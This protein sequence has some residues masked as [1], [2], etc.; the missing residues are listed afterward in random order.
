MIY[1]ETKEI[2]KSYGIK[3]LFEG[4]SFTICEGDKIALV[5]GNGS[6]KS[7][8]MKILAAQE[9]TDKGQ[10]LFSKDA[11]VLFFE[12]DTIYDKN[13][14]AENFLYDFSHP[15][16][17]ALKN[18]QK[19]LEEIDLM[20]EALYQMEKYEVWSL[21]AQMNQILDQLH[22][23]P[24]TSRMENLSGG[25]VKRLGLAKLLLNILLEEGH[26]LLMLDEPTN[27]LDTEMVEWLEGYVNQQRLTLLMVTHD[28]IFLD[29]TCQTIWE[30]DGGNL[31][32]HK[33]DYAQYLMNKSNRMDSMES[34]IGK[35]KNLYRKEL[36][37]MRRQ[38]K[39]RTSKSKSRIDA[40][41][42]TQTTA[43]QV[44]DTKKVVLD[45]QMTRLGGKI[46]EMK[47]VSKSYG[48]LDILNK[49]SYVFQKGDRIGI[50]GKNG[51]GKSTFLNIIQGLEPIDGGVREVGETVAFGYYTQKGL[52]LPATEQRVIEYIKDIAEF[53]PL[54]NGKSLSASQ[55]LKRFLFN[56]DTQHQWVS[57][58]SGGER[59]RLHLLSVL[60]KNP[61]FLILDEPTNDLD[62][63][64]LSILEDFLMEYQG[65]L[66]IVSHDRY[67]MNRV[68]DHLF[69][70]E[71]EARVS[72]FIGTYDEYRDKQKADSTN[73][74]QSRQPVKKTEPKETVSISVKKISHKEKIEKE[75]IE[76]ELPQLQEKLK[77]QVD[78][79]ANET[80][81]ENINSLGKEIAL[82]NQEVDQLE[83]RWL[84]LSEME[85]GV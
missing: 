26:F 19:A 72:D 69:V 58:L 77:Q 46:L 79:L 37:W 16:I 38:P 18:Y 68:V 44:I 63:P 73:T 22:L 20:E 84:E 82:L 42:E 70:F 83:M 2:A 48:E 12:Q 14:I 23:P 67:F 50:I 24:L 52:V 74:T 71:G 53:F 1:I 21:E 45:M 10:V 62:L 85:Q 49:F 54:S 34:T 41:F 11:K 27:H 7:T 66:L 64:T 30:L 51:V 40:F 47:S 75:K 80:N 76:K 43:N 29:Q 56:D 17:D 5:A 59:K 13:Q 9:K 3:N 28:R 36:D 15:K 31:H 57:K 33:G 4:L 32:V 61:N 8:L 39:A 81:Y 55:F 35:A 65:C 78:S 6:G 25:Q 60:F